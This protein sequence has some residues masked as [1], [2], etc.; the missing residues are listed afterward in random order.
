MIPRA[1]CSPFEI[2]ETFS[3]KVIELADQGD[4]EG[5]FNMMEHLSELER[6]NRTAFIFRPIL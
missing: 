2:T 1:G 4:I 5:A 3:G 6:Y